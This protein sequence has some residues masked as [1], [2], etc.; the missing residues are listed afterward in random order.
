VGKTNVGLK[1]EPLPGK[2]K[3]KA[4]EPSKEWLM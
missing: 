4:M 3:K 2:K 1:I